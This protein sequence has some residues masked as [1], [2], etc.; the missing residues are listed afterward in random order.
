M[1]LLQLRCIL[2]AIRLHTNLSKLIRMFRRVDSIVQSV[3]MHVTCS[4]L[5]GVEVTRLFPGSHE[6][7]ILARP[8]TPHPLAHKNIW[9]RGIIVRI[10][11]GLNIAQLS[12]FADSNSASVPAQ[13]QTLPPP[14]STQYNHPAICSTNHYSKTACWLYFSQNFEFLR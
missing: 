14:C 9:R 10:C 13:T 6:S 12:N 5:S 7:C 8:P 3:C 1:T 4:A 2:R 11:C